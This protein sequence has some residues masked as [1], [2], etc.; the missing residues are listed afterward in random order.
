MVNDVEASPLKIK[1]ETVYQKDQVT[2]I[3]DKVGV[4][5]RLQSPAADDSG[6]RLDFTEYQIPIQTT[7][8][9]PFTVSD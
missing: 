1:K 5:L 4:N 7:L 8:Q 2:Y 3:S 9:C 6:G